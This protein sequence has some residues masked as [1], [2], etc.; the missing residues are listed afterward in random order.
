VW[1]SRDDSQRKKDKSSSNSS[2]PSR[3]ITTTGTPLL[4]SYLERTVGH[5]GPRYFSVIGFSRKIGSFFKQSLLSWGFQFH[6]TSTSHAL[7]LGA[8]PVP[9]T[10]YIISTFKDVENSLNV[11]SSFTI[12][13]RL[14]LLQK[15]SVLYVSEMWETVLSV[16]ISLENNWN[17]SN[18]GNCGRRSFWRSW[19]YF[20]VLLRVS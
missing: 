13:C 18:S 7:K 17:S 2:K 11:S 6:A 14:S 15:K 4:I 12:S 5:L 20:T 16:A 8:D 19:R 1:Q 3:W 9:F 10:E